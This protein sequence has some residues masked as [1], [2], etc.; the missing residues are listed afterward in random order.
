MESARNIPYLRHIS[1]HLQY[2]NPNFSRVVSVAPQ[3][4]L[5]VSQMYSRHSHVN[6]TD[7]GRQ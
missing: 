6:T 1:T 3:G 7:V 4:E 5:Q 2:F